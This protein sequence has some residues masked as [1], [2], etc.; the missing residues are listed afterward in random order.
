[1][2]KDEFSN[3]PGKSRTLLLV[4][5][6]LVVAAAFAYDR[7]VAKPAVDQALAKIDELTE[8]GYFEKTNQDV[9]EVV[10]KPPAKQWKPGGRQDVIVETY[11]WRRGLPFLTYDIHVVYAIIDGN[12]YFY[13]TV[14]GKSP[15]ETDLPRV[16]GEGVVLAEDQQVL[17]A[18][19]GDP[20]I[21]P[22]TVN[23]TDDA[24]KDDAKKDD[25]KKDDAKKDDAKKDE[26][27]RG[28]PADKDGAATDGQ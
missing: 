16:K 17:R 24:K 12:N 4:A 23:E 15:V 26:A 14:F 22:E 1:M 6:L 2:T 13:R 25:A 27:T 5:V 9:Q 8:T 3:S 20:E 19:A 18:G 21:T 11:Q 7:L 10:A 28:Q